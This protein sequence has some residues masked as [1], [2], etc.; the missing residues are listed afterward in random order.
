MTPMMPHLP[1]FSP[2][3]AVVASDEEPVFPGLSADD[4]LTLQFTRPTNR[5]DVSTT[6]KVNALLAFTPPLASALRGSWQGDGTWDYLVLT[7]LGTVNPNTSATFLASVRVSVLPGGA[8]G[9][10][11]APAQT[12][13]WWTRLWVAPGAT[14]R[15]PSS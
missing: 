12:S 7:L 2:C 14:R 5:P 13:P 15:S 4:V 3:A 10:R 11:Q 6:A 9:T 1:M 8:C